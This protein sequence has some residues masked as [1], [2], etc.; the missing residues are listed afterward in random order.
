MPGRLILWTIIFTL[1]HSGCNS[2]VEKPNIVIFFI[3][4]MGWK[5]WSG[6]GSD[7]FET[8]NIDRIARE[9]INFTNGYVNAANCSPSRCCILSGQYTPRTNFYNVWTI[10]RGDKNKDRLS[11]SEVVDNQTFD[12][13]KLSFAEAMKKAGYKTAMYGKWHVSG[14]DRQG[15]GNEGGVSAQMQGFDEVLEHPAGVLGDLFRENPDDPKQMFTYT[16]RAIKFAEDCVSE[17]NPFLIYMAHHAVHA[18]NMARPET[19]AGYMDKK[20]GIFHNNIQPAYGA[21]M[22]DLDASI[23]MFMEKLQESGIDQE[24]VVIFLSDNGGPADHGSQA[25]LRSWKG[26]YYEGGIR[27]PF[28]V[29]WP[30]KIKP[31]TVSNTPV[32]A[33]DLYPTMLELAGVRNMKEHLGGYPLDGKSIVSELF[34][35]TSEELEDRAIFWHF[36]AYL[37]GNPKYTGTRNYPDYRA[38]PVSVIRKGDWKL[39]M[40]LE[41][42]SLDGGRANIASNNAIELYNLRDDPGESNNLALTET[43]VLDSLLDELLTWQKSINATIPREPNPEIKLLE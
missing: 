3:D 27:V 38:E 14:Y 1:F 26:S 7:Y 15:S 31:G 6:G 29:R 22:D 33:I 34:G 20:Q 37:K 24:T 16:E 43:V 5:D 25:P 35:N 21:M 36:P 4:D 17:D 12:E 39:M 13:K 19:L 18:R 40:F 28:L 9:G 8:P 41:E 2:S 30:G 23:G 32:M 11:L 10:H 42:W